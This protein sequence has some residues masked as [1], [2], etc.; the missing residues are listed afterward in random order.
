LEERRGEDIVRCIV[1]SKRQREDPSY[2]AELISRRREE[3]RETH[4]WYSHAVSRSRHKAHVVLLRVS[5]EE[6]E[7]WR[8][9]S[10]YTTSPS[11]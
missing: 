9:G 5:W 4:R 7:N 3:K 1:D 11:F 8:V 6:E 2:C 10:L